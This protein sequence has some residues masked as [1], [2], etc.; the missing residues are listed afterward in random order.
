MSPRA[1]HGH[2]RRQGISEGAIVR[3]ANTPHPSPMEP[4]ARTYPVSPAIPITQEAVDEMIANDPEWN[5]WREQEARP[6][7]W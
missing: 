6:R 7:L 3:V 1:G 5:A 4:E 2:G